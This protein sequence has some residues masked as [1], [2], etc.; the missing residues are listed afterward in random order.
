MIDCVAGHFPRGDETATRRA[1]DY[2]SDKAEECRGHAEHHDTLAARIA[3][4]LR[5]ATGTAITQNFRDLAEKFRAQAEF[6]DTVVEQLYEAANSIEEQKW[7]VIGFATV[8]AWQLSRA[9]LMFSPAGAALEFRIDSMA[10]DTACQVAKR[11]FLIFL[12]G[13]TSKYATQRGTIVLAG[14]AMFWGATQVGG[15]SAAVQAGQIVAGNRE[16]MDWKT[17]GIAAAAG[18]VGGGAGA[19]AGS[20]VGGRWIIPNTVSRA[21]AATSTAARVG[22]QLTGTSLVGA[23]GGLAGGI[24]GALTSILLSGQPFTTKALTEGLLPAVTGGFLGAAAHGASEIRTATKTPET[25]VPEVTAPVAPE[26]NTGTGQ[27][28]LTQAL[29]DALAEHGILTRDFNPAD[30]AGS[31]QQQ[32]NQLV[33]RLRQP[34]N[35]FNTAPAPFIREDYNISI[36]K[37]KDSQSPLPDAV[38]NARVEQVQHPDAVVVANEAPRLQTLYAPHVSG[39]PPIITQSQGAPGQPGNPQAGDGPAHHGADGS[40]RPRAADPAATDQRP[41]SHPGDKEA[42]NAR[43]HP[44]ETAAG[45]QRPHPADNEAPHARQR[46]DEPTNARQRADEPTPQPI[47]QPD[48]APKEPVTSERPVAVGPS[49]VQE[50][51]PAPVSHPADGQPGGAR[52]NADE[53]ASPHPAQRGGP[54]PD[55]AAA[56]GGQHPADTDGVDGARPHPADD[57]P[58]DVRTPSDEPEALPDAQDGPAPDES[59]ASGG[60]NPAD[61][62]MVGGPRPHAADSDTADGPRPHP[63]DTDSEQPQ[64]V[65]TAA[66]P[67]AARPTDAAAAPAAARPADAAAAHPA[68]GRPAR[69]RQDN[70]AGPQQ[71]G[72]DR[73]PGPEGGAPRRGGRRRVVAPETSSPPPDLA[74]PVP[75]DQQTPVLVNAL[76]PDEAGSLVPRPAD[77]PAN[78]PGVTAEADLTATSVH[79]G[80]T[81]DPTTISDHTA[82]PEVRPDRIATPEVRPDPIDRATSGQQPPPHPADDTPASVHLDEPVGEQPAQQYDHAPDDAPASIGQHPAEP[83]PVDGARPHPAEND[84]ANTHT[85]TD[86]PAVQHNPRPD[87]AGATGKQPTASE[88]S[89]GTPAH[90]ADNDPVNTHTNTDEPA[91]QHNPRP[92][93]AHA[94]GKQPTASEPSDGTPAHPADN[95]P[96]NTHTNTDEPAPQHNRTP[97]EDHTTAPEATDGARPHS[98]AADADSGS[99]TQSTAEANA[100]EPSAGRQTAEDALQD[101]ADRCSPDLPEEQ[102]LV[103]ASEETLVEM[104]RSGDQ[105]EVTAALIETIRRGENKVL[106]WTQVAAMLAMRD[107]PVNMDA[108]EGKSLVFL[109]HA[110]RDAMEHGAVQVITTRDNLANREFVRYKEVLGPLGIEVV[111]MN[112]DTAPPPPEPGKPTIYIG[113]QQDVGFAAL[114]DNWVPGRRAAIDEIDEALVHADTQYILSD[115]AGQLAETEVAAQV[116]DARDFLSECLDRGVLTESDFGR[117]ADQRGGPANL[118]ETGRQSL[119]RQLGRALTDDELGRLN[120]AASAKWEYVENVHYVRHEIDG[121]ERIFIIDQTTHKVMFDPETSSESRWNGGLAQAIEAKHELAIRNDPNSS[122]SITAQK[123]FSSENYDQITGASGTAEGSAGTLKSRFGMGDVVKID[124]FTDS[125]LEVRQDTISA[126]ETAKLKQVAADT[127]EM[128]KTGRPQLIL[129][130]RNDLVGALANVMKTDHPDVEFIAVDAKWFLEHGTS[131]EDNLQLIFDAAGQEGK[132]LIINMQGARGVDIPIS[133]AARDLGGLHVAV[134]GRSALSRDIDIQAENRAARNGEPGSVQYYTAPTDGLYAPTNNPMVKQVVVKYVNEYHQAA[135]EHQAAPTAETQARLTKAEK[136]LRDL[137]TPLQELAGAQHQLARG[138]SHTPGPSAHAPPT[139]QSEDPNRRHFINQMPQELSG[140]TLNAATAGQESLLDDK[141]SKSGR[142]LLADTA[143]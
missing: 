86:E 10:T 44:D 118:T 53:P 93:E 117:T 32:L 134:T 105:A 106:R 43:Q 66:A 64:P 19:V 119:E 51:A 90:P 120:M 50:P 31:Q 16:S 92:D 20:W 122:K 48:P 65:A 88:P 113:T 95:D 47:R 84:P 81:H 14:K 63:A 33:T 140:G 21:E 60:P 139:T 24:L 109:A 96:A 99:T 9:A 2:W 40:P 116:T 137:A 8:L 72:R 3:N 39:T 29:V 18:G 138:G 91:V 102:R 101:Y 35:D 52:T 70:P 108:G 7:T 142:P 67:T 123:L 76:G 78:K 30:P 83:G 22:F 15:I 79:S 94:T 42:V 143:E 11:R 141:I 85:N 38:N 82:T 104:L 110:A 112:P 34:A 89:D 98:A 56:S 23:T 1:A 57:K 68:D 130:D 132:V 46:P 74:A 69:A 125:K 25:A 13:Q 6:I 77:S 12:A 4:E 131:A 58:A 136:N 26:A 127:Q 55:D 135:A 133:G 124:R 5:G 128:Q 28:P 45:G 103:N 61:S 59:S 17:V 62:E 36:W 54:T 75:Q 114:R 100:A 80:T 49:S 126:D 27:R 41:S 107:G 87:E 111:R 73:Q 129:C 71:R 115:G 37:P 97:D 121:Q